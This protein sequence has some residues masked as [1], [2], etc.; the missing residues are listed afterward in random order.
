MVI[1]F[2]FSFAFR[3]SASHGYVEGLPRQPCCFLAFLF[4]GDGPFRTRGTLDGG[5]RAHHDGAVVAEGL[6]PLPL[7]EIPAEQ[8]QE[9]GGDAGEKAQP[10]LPCAASQQEE[11]GQGHR[12][13]QKDQAQD[14]P[15]IRREQVAHGVA[16][17][18]IENL[19]D[20]LNAVLGERAG[21]VQIVADIGV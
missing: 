5:D 7:G 2:L 14:S 16:P 12:S 9:Q 15:G 6:R 8:G 13:G 10:A 4:H 11:Q 18:L 19:R 1:S 17:L 3:F 21:I 20:F